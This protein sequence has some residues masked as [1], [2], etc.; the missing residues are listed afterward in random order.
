MQQ[1]EKNL[2]IKEK[3]ENNIIIIRSFFL[4]NFRTYNGENEA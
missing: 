4:F 3:E 2:I 1:K